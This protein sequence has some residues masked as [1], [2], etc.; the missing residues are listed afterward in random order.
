MPLD[1]NE[2]VSRYKPAMDALNARLYSWQPPEDTLL[3]RWWLT[4]NETGDLTRLFI[5]DAH[6]LPDFYRVFSYPTAL[7]YSLSEESEIDNA[8]WLTPADNTSKY[9]VAYS[10]MWSAT[11]GGR[12]QLQFA[13]LAYPLAFEF[14]SAIL[15]MTWQPELLDIHTKLGYTIV[16]C[17]PYMHDQPFVYIVH[18]TKEAYLA[19]RFYSVSQRRLKHG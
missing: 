2:I 12:K 6:R 17:I 3:L 15:G 19:S 8:F 13:A 14:Y 7:L 9:R 11:R 16:G 1:L 5:S 4:L 18:L 10:G